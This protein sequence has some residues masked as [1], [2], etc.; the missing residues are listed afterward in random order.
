MAPGEA[1]EVMHLVE[2]PYTQNFA[3]AGD[4]LQS[5][6]GLRMVLRGRPD[7]GQLDVAEQPIIV[8]NQGEVDFDPVLHGRIREPFRHALSLRF[9]G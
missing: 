3:D 7:D 5:V 1:G 9:V 6:E 2:Q 4:G 8:V